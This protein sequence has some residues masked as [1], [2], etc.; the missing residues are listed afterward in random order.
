MH[1]FIQILTNLI[2]DYGYW[3]IGIAM[4]LDSVNIPIPSEI[5]L[6][7]GG[8]LASISKLNLL[9]VI[10]IS[11]ITTTLGSIL[12]Y[13]LGFYG[14]GPFLEK[15]GK[16]F[17]I[18]KEDLELATKWLNKYGNWIIFTGRLIPGVRTFISLP[19][20]IAKINMKIFLIYTFAGSLLWCSLLTYI[21]YKL[22]NHWEQIEVFF[23][24]FHI[25]I[26]GIALVL[27][28]LYIWYKLRK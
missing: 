5:T 10:I 17:F 21:G 23:E 26:I 11:T 3:V 19:A 25:I 8:Y 13:Y 16:Y 20:G 14:G 6:P 7:F 4:F 2:S 27:V 18:S 1:Q 22:G 24:K 9:A 28:I 12:N 15:Y